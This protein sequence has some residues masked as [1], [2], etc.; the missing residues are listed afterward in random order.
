MNKI[1]CTECDHEVLEGCGMHITAGEFICYWCVNRLPINKLKDLQPINPDDLN[2][3]EHRIN[4]K[5][6][7]G[8]QS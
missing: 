4:C 7:D 5:T 1:I 2:K 6:L 8:L 3:I